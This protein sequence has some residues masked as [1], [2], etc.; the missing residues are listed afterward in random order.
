MTGAIIWMGRNPIVSNIVIVFVVLGGL[1]GVKNTTLE[2]LPDVSMDRIQVSVVYKGAS[3]AD[4]EEG[5]CKR[6]EERVLGLES[7]SR[8]RSTAIEG[9]GVVTLELDRDADPPAVLDAVK[10]AVDRID[11]LPELAERPVIQEVIRRNRVVDV[12]VYGNATERTLK[13]VATRVRNELRV[14]SGISLVDMIGVRADEISIEVGEEALRRHG[15]TFDQVRSAVAASSV[16]LPGGSVRTES[17]EILIRTSGLLQ[18]GA[19]YEDVVVERRPD[20]T[21]LRLGQIARVVDGFEASDLSSRFNGHPA[22]VVQVFRV[23]NESTLSV[24]EAVH[25]YIEQQVPLLPEG[26][27]LS[28]ARDGA[29]P[30]NSRLDLLVGNALMGLVLVF[31]CLSFFLEL[32]LAFWVMIGIPVSFLGCFILIQPFDVT[33]NMISLFGFIIALG[34]VVDDAIVVGESVFS[35][36]EAVE[37]RGR[38]ETEAVSAEVAARRQKVFMRAA[39]DGALSVSTPVTFSVL[40][41]VAAFLPLLFVVGMLGK[42]MAEI[43]VVVIAIL[44]FS[45]AESLF[46]LPAHLSARH[47]GRIHQAVEGV[48]GGLLA[49]HKKVRDGLDLKM[50]AFIEHR[51][52]PALERSLSSPLTSLA[53]GVASILV[54]V[55]FLAGGHMRFTF[56]PVVDADWL[57]VS[58]RMPEGSTAAQT[59]RAIRQIETAAISVRDEYD[60]DRPAD[61]PSIFRNIFSFV[62]DQPAGHRGILSSP[63]S[64][65]SHANLGEVAIEFLPSEE[66]FFSGAEIATLIRERTGD[67]PGAESVAYQSSGLQAGPALEVDLAAPNFDT[68]LSASGMLKEELKSYPGTWEIEDSFHEGKEEMQL[69]LKPQAH[70]LGVTLADLARQ[71]RQGFS[72]DEA[73]RFQRNQEDVRVMVRYPEEQ[74]RSP[75]DVEGIRIRTP[76]GAEVPFSEVA[77]VRLGKGYAAIHRSDGQRVVTVTAQVEGRA[78]SP[79]QI[80]RDLTA[81]FLP[82]LQ[83]DYPSLRASFE[84]QRRERRE[85]LQSLASG[86]GVALL[87][88][89]ALLAIPFR[90]YMQPLIVVSAIPFGAVGAVWGHLILGMDLTLLSLLGIV[91]LAG[92]VV[93][94]STL[95]ISTFN[96]LRRNGLDTDTALAEASCRRF[97]P[98][99]LTSITTFA[100]LFPMIIERSVQAQFLIPM[101]VSL[102][103][104]ILLATAV[105][106]G[107]LPALTKMMCGFQEWLGH[108][109]FDDDDVFAL[110]DG[111]AA[112]DDLR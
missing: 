86:F 19:A 24:S 58:V 38:K 31:V 53:V 98:I 14:T 78:V 17:G 107:L 4:V 6:I 72:G 23:G 57:A 82:A 90:S 16:E 52:R 44:L 61:A 25:A 62:G 71:V 60:A 12:V 47:G 64:A 102:G 100:G 99:V 8:V 74:R 95:L 109:H 104:G 42:L 101:A 77:E 83:D 110:E 55:G 97:R 66:R 48:F 111:G 76:G 112:A 84:G 20:G 73:L 65:G 26:V 13:A 40:T 85:S 87:V 59:E 103:I 51:Y 32:H 21:A 36:R 69:S 106:L 33:V 1:L 35:F 92:V 2:A 70:A 28:Y 80:V 30:L 7:V 37:G 56:M 46:I 43:P 75:G 39:I 89:L 96:D 68:V 105:V 88:I 54:T 34:I 11:A 22:A 29:Q 18:T 79:Q 50:Q 5:V 93:N 45:L 10:L 27:F 94:D 41:T 3:P 108:S 91:A 67:I 49:R 15:L 81:G 63:A 9:L